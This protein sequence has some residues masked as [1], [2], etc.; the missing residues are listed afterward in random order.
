MKN[1][2]RLIVTKDDCLIDFE[3]G[4]WLPGGHQLPKV[5]YDRLSDFASNS[6][7]LFM[8]EVDY[9]P[10][11]HMLFPDEY[12]GVISLKDGTQIEIIPRID[13]GGGKD[14]NINDAKFKILNMLDSMSD[15]PLKSI[16]KRYFARE[17]LNLF[18]ICVRMFIEE[19]EGILFSCLKQT[20]VPYEGNEVFVKGKT[21]YHIHARK[22][23]AHKER[24]YVEYDIYSVNRAENRLI[25]STL[26]LLKK[27]SANSRNLK[28]I[29]GLIPAFDGVDPSVRHELDF[30]LCVL[31]RGM[32]KY[33]QAIGWAK[34]FLLNQG[35]TFFAGGKVK[36]ALLF[37]INK[38]FSGYI[39]AKIRKKLD[40]SKYIF[41]TPE[42]LTNTLNNV[43]REGDVASSVYIDSITDG[44]NI[45]LRFV[46][47]DIDNFFD[48]TSKNTIVLFPV[49]EIINVNPSRI[50][51]NFYLIDMNNPDETVDLLLETYF[52]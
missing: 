37:P 38:I 7:F 39:S 8:Q 11:Q 2:K 29:S 24:F 42:N 3:P 16:N 45:Q 10:E 35:A 26:L 15:V 49:T 14:W 51:E 50:K 31:D 22:N 17:N 43:H 47:D 18:E 25:L 48:E 40:R 19:V 44:R 34:L 13:Q 21:I 33:I 20:Y 6:R 23:F 9:A 28:K 4:P 1:E 41:D 30:S 36:Y 12:V 27:L 52:K 32:G 5:D 46:F